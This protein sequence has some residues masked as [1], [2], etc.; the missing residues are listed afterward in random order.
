MRR[1]VMKS[2]TLKSGISGLAIF[3]GTISSAFAANGRNDSSGVL[4]WVFLGFCGLII[5]AQLMPAV[6]LMFGMV[7]SF[8][9]VSKQ[10]TS[11]Q[12]SR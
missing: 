2:N 1:S 5:A 4:A 8:K 9:P 3:L 7:K 6:L 10:V 12:H 11:S